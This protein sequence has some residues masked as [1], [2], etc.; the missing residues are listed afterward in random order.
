MKRL[1]IL[2]ISILS[3]AGLWAQ[4]SIDRYVDKESVVGASKFTS[5]VERDPETR[6]II[7]VVKVRELFRSTDITACQSKFESEKHTGRYSHKTDANNRHTLLL[8]V[9]NG[10]KE[11]IYMLQYTAVRPA[12]LYDGKVTIVVKKKNKNK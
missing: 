5:V 11:R 8:V 3:S 2:L 9:D 6:E 1:T 4:N 7:R 12:H 10:D